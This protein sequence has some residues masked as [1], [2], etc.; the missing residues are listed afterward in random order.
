MML[1]RSVSRVRVCMLACVRESVVALL[2]MLTD[3]DNN[4]LSVQRDHR[5]LC[6]YVR[7][8]ESGG[9]HARARVRVWLTFSLCL[10]L[11]LW[12]AFFVRDHVFHSAFHTPCVTPT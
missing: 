6:V 7:V 11:S 9:L 4:A 2:M 1:T 12:L 10:S 5:L 3:D 8:C